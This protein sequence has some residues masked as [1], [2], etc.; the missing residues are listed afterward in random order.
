MLFDA[1]GRSFLMIFML[2]KKTAIVLDE[3]TCF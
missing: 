1:V 2:S 3:K